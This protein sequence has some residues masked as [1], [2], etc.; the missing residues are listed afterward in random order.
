MFINTKQK[1][2]VSKTKI[3]VVLTDLLGVTS[4]KH[5][6][7]YKGSLMLNDEGLVNS[8]SRYI[9]INIYHILTVH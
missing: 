7:A 6:M 2:L 5:F 1:K 9:I 3:T 8:F 4:F